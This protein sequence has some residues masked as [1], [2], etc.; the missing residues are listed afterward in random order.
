M[1]NTAEEYTESTMCEIDL[2][3]GERCGR[4]TGH[5]YQNDHFAPL[6]VDYFTVLSSYMSHFG[7]DHSTIESVGT[8]NVLFLC[9]WSVRPA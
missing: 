8:S 7:R 2:A 4:L 5:G 9:S 3:R 1:R 6:R